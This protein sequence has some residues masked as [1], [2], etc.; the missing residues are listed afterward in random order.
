MTYRP[1]PFTWCPSTG[2]RHATTE[3]TPNDGNTFRALCGESPVAN[4]NAEAWFSPT[5][6]TCN[7]RAHELAGILLPPAQFDTP[8]GTPPA[9]GAA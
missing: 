5:C 4:R 6:T 7:T 3:V 9:R 1:H 8:T 2:A